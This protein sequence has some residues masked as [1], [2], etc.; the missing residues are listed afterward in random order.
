MKP[1]TLLKKSL[2]YKCFTVN[3]AKFLRTPF[4]Q[5]TSGGFIYFWSKLFVI[6]QTL[7]NKTFT[8]I[9]EFFLNKK[10]F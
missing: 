4:L 10:K 8:K 2:W 5:N 9:A 6:N 7:S 3:F 1:A